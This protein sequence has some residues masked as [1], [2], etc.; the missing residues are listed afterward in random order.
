[1]SAN[2]PKPEEILGSGQ[3]SLAQA[4]TALANESRKQQTELVSVVF[5]R[6][7]KRWFTGDSAGFAPSVAK[8]LIDAK[9]ASYKKGAVKRAVEAVVEAVSG[10]GEPADGEPEGKAPG[11]VP[12]VDDVVAAGYDREAAPLI[13]AQEQA[14]ADAGLEPYGKKKATEKNIAAALKKAGLEPKA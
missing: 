11:A 13:V 8:R 6:T 3:S 12:T 5:R 4:G 1:M 10:D 7:W 14:K 2:E 9:V